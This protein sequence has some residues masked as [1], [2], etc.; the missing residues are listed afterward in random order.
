M[1]RVC[2]AVVAIAVAQA[3]AGAQVTSGASGASG[4]PRPAVAR[5]PVDPLLGQRLLDAEDSRAATPDALRLLIETAL[6][7]SGPYR[8][9][10]IRAVGRLERPSLADTLMPLL[11]DS[12]GAVRLATAHAVGQLIAPMAI[13]TIDSIAGARVVRDVSARLGQF[14]TLAEKEASVR[15]ALATSIGRAAYSNVADRASAQAV[16]LSRVTGVRSEMVGVLRGLDWLWRRRG[17]VPLASGD[18]AAAVRRAA[19]GTADSAVR[20]WAMQALV[21]G[22]A[23]TTATIEVAQ[24]DVDAQVRRQGVLGLAALRDT[25]GA[26]ALHARSVADVSPLVRIEAMRSAMLWQGSAGCAM[27]AAGLRDAHPHVALTAIDVVPAAC[28]AAVVPLLGELASGLSASTTGDAL[29]RAVHAAVTLAQLDPARAATPVRVAA[30]HPAWISR[31][32][33]ARAA[34]RLRDEGVL[35]RLSADADDNV[36]E[37]ALAGLIAM[38]HPKTDSVATAQLQRGDYQLVLNAAEW[39]RGKGVPSAA[40]SAAADALERISRER[41]DTSRD[42]RLALVRL[43]GKGGTAAM[44]SRLMPFTRD[45]DPVIAAEAARVVSA[46]T[47]STVSAVPAPLP[48]SPVRESDARAL[49]GATLRVTM[50]AEAGGGTFDVLLDPGTAPGTVLRVVQLARAGHYTGR[51]FHRVVPTFVIQGGSPGANEYMGD[52]P[53]LRDEVG[54]AVHARGTLGISTRGR[55]TGDAQLFV[56]LVENAR[57]DFQYTVFGRVVKGMEV[58]DRVLEGDRM[59]RVEVVGR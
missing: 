10:A 58:V 33:S 43:I 52:G 56:N 38:S 4:A 23:M 18:A 47:G 1:V 9:Q 49:V 13:G 32:Y 36:R 53:Y 31:V 28:V 21:S 41:R 57:L 11:R 46:W 8:V 34:A 40:A 29:H 37:A 50:A 44:A 3:V 45:F 55:D 6:R 5:P 51:T 16:L 26:G 30:S 24:R 59:E 39:L 14:L 48:L 22:R 17:V 54:P 42:P 27:L 2:V 20:R 25:T 19:Q 12:S 15:G 7:G 35:M